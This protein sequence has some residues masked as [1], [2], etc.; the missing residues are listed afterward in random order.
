LTPTLSLIGT[1]NPDF[2]NVEGA[3][4]GIDFSYGP[5]FVPDR[6]PFFQE[7]ADTYAMFGID[8]VYFYSLRVGAFDTGLNLWGK[9][10]PRD[11][12][13]VLGAFDLGHRADWVVRGRHDL[14]P[15]A[16]VNVG[17]INR[18]G[19][20]ASNRVL[21]VAEQTRVGIWGFDAHWAGSWAGSR[22]TGDIAQAS[23]NYQSPR[24]FAAVEPHYV[25]PGFRDDLGFIPF[26]DFKG[27]NTVVSYS[28]EW[29]RGPL[30]SFG[31]S[32]GTSDSH[33]Y[34]GTLFRQQRRASFGVESRSDYALSVGWDGGRFEEFDDSV[35]TVEAR[36][37][38]SNPFRHYG[39]GFSWGR[40]AGDP[41]TFLTP[42]A[43]WRFGERFTIGL[44]SALLYHTEDAQQHIVTFNYDLSPEQGIGGRVVA[45]TGGTNAYLAYR[46]SGYGGVETFLIL[47][48]PNARKFRARVMTK[49][50]W[51]M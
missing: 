40:R 44:R 16:N 5:R 37:R 14:G 15:T 12:V 47:G 20:G 29:R 6:R 9:L 13:G 34:D 39:L 4:E 51:S 8:E 17:L 28:T 23:L 30:R 43:T 46:R 45:Q 41:I 22:H 49:V 38:A 42:F 26:T 11:T 32:A 36:A 27:V 31:A 48:D 3:V 50:V 25:R 21:R 24:W 35:F 19:E 1:V 7:G 10:T 33:H 18:D 2:R